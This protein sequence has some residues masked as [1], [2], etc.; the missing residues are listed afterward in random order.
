LG[1][2]YG[3]G[4][5]LPIFTKH[6]LLLNRNFKRLSRE[7][8]VWAALSHPNIAEFLGFADDF[9]DFTAMISTVRHIC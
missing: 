2:I 1:D 4:T 5:P 9:G 8:R 7:I 6:E 3:T